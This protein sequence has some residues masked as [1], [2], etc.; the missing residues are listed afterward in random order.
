MT[1]LA[2]IQS[3]RHQD[4][5]NILSAMTMPGTEVSVRFCPGCGGVGQPAGKYRD[6]CPN[7]SKARFIPEPLAKH[8]HDI[9]QIALAASIAKG[10]GMKLVPVEPTEEQVLAGIIAFQH[11]TDTLGA[12]AM[13]ET[14]CRAVYADMVEARPDMESE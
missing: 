11:L 12:A 9:F 14:L 5:A 13:P 3:G 1:A 6:C 10:A 2:F 7:G 8:C 4:A